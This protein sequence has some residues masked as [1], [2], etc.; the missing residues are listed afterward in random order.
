MRLL[1][2]ATVLLM[3]SISNVAS[4]QPSRLAC[5]SF[6]QLAVT[7]VQIRQQGTEVNSV[8]GY[9]DANL[10]DEYPPHVFDLVKKMIGDA[11]SRKP[12][13]PASLENEARVFAKEQR[14]ECNRLYAKLGN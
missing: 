9:A 13:S 10:R 7:V 4:A 1:I 8:L 14:R 5:D 6:A 12:V 3:F 11:F 2:P